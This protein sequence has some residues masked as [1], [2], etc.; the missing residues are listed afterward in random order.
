MAMPDAQG[1]PPGKARGG[2]GRD[3]DR[4]DDDRLGPRPIGS[5]GAGPAA[6]RDHP[7][8]GHDGP[9]R[10]KPI[11]HGADPLPEHAR[12]RIG[13]TR[14]NHGISIGRVLYTPDG[15]SIVATDRAGAVLV[16]D[17]ATGR[18]VRAIGGPASAYPQIA[19]S[20]DGLTLATLDQSG[21]LRLWDL[22]SGRE[23]RRWHEVPGYPTHL[24]FSPD[25]RTLAADLSTQD[26]TT[27]KAQHLIM[28]WD[29][30]SP[31]E[32][33]RQFAADWRVLNGLAFTP[34]GKALVTG[35]NNMESQIAGGKPE[36]GTMWLWDVAT[37]L[38]RR[39][40][41]VEARSPLDRRFSRRTAG[42]RRRRRQ[43]HPDI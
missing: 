41:P 32:H 10:P 25:G 35:S 28:L 5:A 33:R 38:K 2:R 3:R 16:W 8:S 23:R 31:T 27:L 42:G 40:F 37:G 24:T 6:V 15:K 22:A 9:A 29:L 4:L 34:D 7:E 39:R 20:P 13:S 11:E 36:S 14:F 30:A 17:A 26:P 43:D 19:L 21:V 18:M 1:P 12:L